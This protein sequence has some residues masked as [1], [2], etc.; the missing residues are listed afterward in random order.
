LQVP[1]SERERT[2]GAPQPRCRQCC[3]VH[4]ELSID[5]E[6][7]ESLAQTRRFRLLDVAPTL[8]DHFRDEMGSYVCTA[9]SRRHDAELDSTVEA[10][11]ESLLEFATVLATQATS[12]GVL[13]Q[14]SGQATAEEKEKKDVPFSRGRGCACRMWKST[15]AARLGIVDVVCLSSRDRHGIPLIRSCHDFAGGSFQLWSPLSSDVF[16]LFHTAIARP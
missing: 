9:T 7:P 12:S 8:G 6:D 5:T 14:S 2:A 13:G 10:A 15:A 3:F 16:L 4:S 1:P 11:V